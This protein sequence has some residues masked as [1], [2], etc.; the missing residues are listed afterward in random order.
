[1]NDEALAN[2]ERD[3]HASVV[4]ERGRWLL[5]DLDLDARLLKL[6]IMYVAIPAWP[7]TW[8]SSTSAASTPL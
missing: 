7:P 3:G 4:D 2:L 6:A 5:T 1:V 8:P